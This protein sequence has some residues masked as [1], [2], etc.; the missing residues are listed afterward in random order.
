MQEGQWSTIAWSQAWVRP[1]RV[2]SSGGAI[3]SPGV[4]GPGRFELREGLVLGRHDAFEWKKGLRCG[5]AD[6]DDIGSLCPAEWAGLSGSGL[7][8]GV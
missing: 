5:G 7:G 8:P 2:V 3:E 6:D 4:M 1:P